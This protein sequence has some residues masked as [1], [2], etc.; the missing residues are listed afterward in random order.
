MSK[1][2]DSAVSAG[3]KY[4]MQ[5]GLKEIFYI[6]KLNKP[7]NFV[8]ACNLYIL[9]TVYSNGIV[10]KFIKKYKILPYLYNFF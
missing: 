1:K 4:L 6:L 3:L 7:L 2:T 8:S 10:T 9:L 5:V